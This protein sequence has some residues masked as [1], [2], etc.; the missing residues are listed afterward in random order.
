[1][2]ASKLEAVSDTDAVSNEGKSLPPSP[3]VRT[4]SPSVATTGMT[5]PSY[6][7][8]I[9]TDWNNTDVG[10]D[11]EATMDAIANP[12]GPRQ[13]M[14]QHPLRGNPQPY[15]NNEGEN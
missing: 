13:P 10:D 4:T 11:F 12:P 14:G 9:D 6:I 8:E 5:V 1:M 3:N 2:E 15:R 7:P